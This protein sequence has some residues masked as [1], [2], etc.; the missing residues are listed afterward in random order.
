MHLIL[1]KKK[2]MVSVYTSVA[3]EILRSVQSFPL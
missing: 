2:Y 1:I 3:C